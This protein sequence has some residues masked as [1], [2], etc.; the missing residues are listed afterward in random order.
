MEKVFFNL[1]VEDDYPPVSSESVWGEKTASSTFIV[2]NIPFYSR[3]ACLHDEVAVIAG[4]DG[5]HLFDKVVTSSGN[6]T[7]RIIFFAEGVPHIS[8]VLESLVNIGCKW[9]GMSKKFFSINIP[10][11]VS[12]D[13]AIDLLAEGKGKDWLDFEYGLVRQ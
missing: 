12:F 3:D 4:V 13:E 5:E 8:P 7:I 9:E 6:S 10:A 2:K 11:E 1:I